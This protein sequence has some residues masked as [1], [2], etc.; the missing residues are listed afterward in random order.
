MLKN[1]IILIK[2]KLEKSISVSQKK[3]EKRRQILS[4]LI[5]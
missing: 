5:L 2:V 4:F 1:D 3:E